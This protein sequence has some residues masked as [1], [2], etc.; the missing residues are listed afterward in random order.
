MTQS[1]LLLCALLG[2]GIPQAAVAQFE[3]VV[4]SRNFSVDDEGAGQQ[5]AMTIWARR[6]MV[7]VHVPAYGA[8]AASTVIYRAD[9]KVS[10][11]LDES[12]KTYFEV[13]LV[14]K[15][16]TP[17]YPHAAVDSPEVQRTNKTRK[18]LGHVCEQV[19]VRRGDLETE[20]WGTKDL[21]DLAEVLAST[22]HEGS[23]AEED[24]DVL[25]TMGL[26]PLLSTTRLEG[27]VLESQEVTRIERKALPSDLFEIPAGYVKQKP[28]EIR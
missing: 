3:G 18:I 7:R 4:Q 28:V 23:P 16:S 8:S 6:H 19:I 21:A 20:V 2:A 24:E 12:S 22:L 17:D 27:R 14:A 25:S 15:P 1:A 10:W 13:S 11:V 9:R 5:Y 26:Y